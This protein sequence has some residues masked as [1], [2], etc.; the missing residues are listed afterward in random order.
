LPASAR[1][2]IDHLLNFI[3]GTEVFFVAEAEPLTLASIQN[4]GP[5]LWQI[6][7][8]AGAA[9][10]SGVYPKFPELRLPLTDVLAEIGHVLLAIAPGSALQSITWRAEHSA[11][12]LG[13][14][15]ELDEAA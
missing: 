6:A 10:P 12:V 7:E 1:G 9:R 15:D 11:G 13:E 8:T 5:G 4:V 3:S 14:D 2:G